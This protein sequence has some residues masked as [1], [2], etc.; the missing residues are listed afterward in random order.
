MEML[1]L[2]KSQVPFKMAQ[3]VKKPIHWIMG[4]KEI[5]TLPRFGNTV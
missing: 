1:V 2:I 3:A 5:A 4:V